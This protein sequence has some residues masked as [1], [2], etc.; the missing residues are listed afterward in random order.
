MIGV[1]ESL[2]DGVAVTCH[3]VTIGNEQSGRLMRSAD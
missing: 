3:L 2:V 1:F